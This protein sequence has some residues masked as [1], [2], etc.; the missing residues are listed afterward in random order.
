M[1]TIKPC[2]F[3]GKFLFWPAMDAD[4]RPVILFKAKVP[5]LKTLLQKYFCHDEDKHI[6]AEQIMME[7]LIL[8]KI[9]YTRVIMRRDFFQFFF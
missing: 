3:P 2:E 9:N 6:P 8:F 4:K 7:V 1:F 5:F